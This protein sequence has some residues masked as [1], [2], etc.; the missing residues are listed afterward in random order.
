MFGKL[1]AS[2]FTG[3]MVGAGAEVIAV[4]CYI[5]SN[6][7]PPGVVEVCPAVLATI[8]GCDVQAIE[9]ALAVLCAEDPR[10]R[11]KEHGG[12]RL[13]PASEFMY[14]V[15]TWPKYNAMRNE[16]ARRTYFREKKRESRARAGGKKADVTLDVKDSQTL[17]NG[18]HHGQPPSTHVEVEV[19][20]DV[21]V[22]SEKKKTRSTKRSRAASPPRST[23]VEHVHLKACAWFAERFKELRGVEYKVQSRDLAAAH[24]LLVKDRVPKDE[25]KLRAERMLTHRSQFHFERASPAHLAS[26]WNTL[27]LD[28]VPL[29]AGERKQAAAGEAWDA[30]E[31]QSATKTPF[32]VETTP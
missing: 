19:E 7:R 1:F 28:V 24:R 17:S 26:E 21:D 5:V 27:A 6:T 8:I 25:W 11:S 2:T 14:D 10:S 29:S 22:E 4:W 18:V 3:S 9:K 12:R 23:V 15:P 32:H 31:Q 20:V 16:E 13:I 30:L